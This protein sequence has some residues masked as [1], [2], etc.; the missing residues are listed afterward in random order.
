MQTP[1][2]VPERF[3]KSK[4]RVVTEQTVKLDSSQ[5]VEEKKKQEQLEVSECS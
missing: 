4:T 5:N 1:E 2:S 3:F